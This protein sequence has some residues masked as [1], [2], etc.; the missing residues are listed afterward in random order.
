MIARFLTGYLVAVLPVAAALWAAVIVIGGAAGAQQAAPLMRFLSSID[1]MATDALAV[2]RPTA[3]RFQL[4]VPRGA[5]WILTLPC[6]VVPALIAGRMAARF[7]DLR[8]GS[9]V[10]VGLRA[11]VVGLVLFGL[12][13]AVG[14]VLG[15]WELSDEP[16]MLGAHP[17]VLGCLVAAVVLPLLVSRLTLLV[18]ARFARQGLVT[19]PLLPPG[20]GGTIVS[21]LAAVLIVLA[22]SLAAATAPFG[23]PMIL[24]LA[25]ALAVAGVAGL[26]T[27]ARRDA[28][29]AQAIIACV[30][31]V[32]LLPTAAAVAGW[33][34]I[35]HWLRE[36]EAAR[37]QIATRP[38]EQPAQAALG[39]P[40]GLDPAQWRVVPL[41][42]DRAGQSDGRALLALPEPA[43]V[44]DL[45]GGRI[46]IMLEAGAL[47]LVAVSADG[48]G[49]GSADPRVARRLQM[50]LP[51]S[52]AQF[53]YRPPN[54]NDDLATAADLLGMDAAAVA[55]STRGPDWVA[56]C[57]SDGDCRIL[58]D[59]GRRGLVLIQPTEPPAGPLGSP[60][61]LAG[62]AS[63]IARSW[64]AG[65]QGAIVTQ[66][67]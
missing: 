45:G 9:V 14:L 12:P 51:G 31:A 49:S 30:A 38:Q 35:A 67:N 32:L 2:I 60:N 53:L 26:L 33:P 54:L 52:R 1:L 44:A 5:L 56:L 37:P 3:G 19:Q 23:L 64:R 48:S 43:S 22:G 20:V 47:Q 13:A 50:S 55:L 65:L 24:R 27:T 7:D 18:A 46:R 36:A 62:Y 66:Q 41:V 8:L 10:F 4:V 59:F 39:R 58:A 16:L 17:T 63:P 42:L 15:A 6:L 25:I 29:T 40:D 61:D 21:T 11:A 57:G 34:M 28:M